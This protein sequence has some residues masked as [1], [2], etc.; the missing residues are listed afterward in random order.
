MTF[1]ELL[2]KYQALLQENDSLKE[3]IKNLKIKFGVSEQ[4]AITD[5]ASETF[6][7]DNLF[8]T[9]SI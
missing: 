6:S 7:V 9:P 5:G 4:R 8:P 2:K 3:E 1:E